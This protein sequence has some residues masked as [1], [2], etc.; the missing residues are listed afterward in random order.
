M[1]RCYLVSYDIS[2]PKRLH[3]VYQLMRGYGE[4]W[5]LSVF[6]C[7]LRGIDRVEMESQL[8]AEINHS[9][10]QILIL[11]LGPDEEAARK[12][13]TA[14]GRPLPPPTKNIIVF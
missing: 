14:L 7:K 12:A 1:Q 8:R 4:H 11:D 3:R 13:F 2:D 10:D 9:E 6:F 5:Q